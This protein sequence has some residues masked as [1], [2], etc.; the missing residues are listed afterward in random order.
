MYDF[1]WQVGIFL[2]TC[3][4]LYTGTK[5]AENH[6]LKESIKW[7]KEDREK[8]LN[9]YEE[10]FNKFYEP[11]FI[12]TKNKVEMRWKLKKEYIKTK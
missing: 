9:T 7:Y 8:L 6:K 10:L 11:D 12:Y 4:V 5:I 3:S 2:V 1:I